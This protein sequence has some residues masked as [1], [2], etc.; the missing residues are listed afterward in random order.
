MVSIKPFGAF[1]KID[2]FRLQ[3]LVHISQLADRRVEDVEEV[4]ACDDEVCV[5]FFCVLFVLF[6]L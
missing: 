1:V 6:Y 3:G 5:L 4:V 2:G